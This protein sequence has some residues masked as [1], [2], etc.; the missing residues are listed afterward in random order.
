MEK[1]TDNINRSLTAI[2]QILGHKDSGKPYEASKGQANPSTFE[3]NLLYK[4]STG[5]C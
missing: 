4:A 5:Y 3:H 1:S 2:I